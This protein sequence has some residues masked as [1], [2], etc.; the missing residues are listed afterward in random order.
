MDRLI[1]G[2]FPIHAQRKDS[3]PNYCGQ[4]HWRNS[5]RFWFILKII[6][7]KATIIP[8]PIKENKL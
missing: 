4:I 1:G 8:S 3:R 6:F 7:L 5:G 2:L